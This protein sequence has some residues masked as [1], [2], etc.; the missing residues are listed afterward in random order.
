MAINRR[1]GG[2][3]TLTNFS[4]P[5]YLSLFRHTPFE[6]FENKDRALKYSGRSKTGVTVA[7]VRRDWYKIISFS[8]F[9]L[10]FFS[11]SFNTSNGGKKKNEVERDGRER[12][13]GR[14][15]GRGAMQIGR[16]GRRRWRNLFR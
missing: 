2:G 9:F 15:R 13:K 11:S 16:S 7:R 6:P 1:G 10:R 3:G 5:P 8:S 12:T 14:E 4:F